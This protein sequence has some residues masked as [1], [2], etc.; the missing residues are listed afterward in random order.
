MK[1][2]AYLSPVNP[3]PSGISDYSEELLPYLGQYADVTLFVADG[4]RPTNAQ[5]ARHLDVLP[6]RRLPTLHRQ[7]PFD[8]IIYHMGNSA[9]HAEIWRAAQAMPGVVVLHEW[10]LHHFML[11]YAVNVLRRP[12]HYREQLVRRYGVAAKGVADEMLRGRLG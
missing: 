3:A 12:Q 1:R 9:V 2:I 6:I 7:R 5:L 8:A 11:W 4:V 10:V